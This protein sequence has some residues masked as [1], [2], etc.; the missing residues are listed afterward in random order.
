MI[1]PCFGLLLLA[2]TACG[3]TPQQTMTPIGP[4]PVRAPSVYG[5]LGERER[6]DLTSD[7]IE[8]LD[9]IGRWLASETEEIRDDLAPRPRAGRQ[10]PD[11]AEIA[12][13]GEA[14]TAA[15]VQAIEG[16]ESLL[17]AEQRETVCALQRE[18]RDRADEAGATDARPM[19]VGGGRNM[20]MVS[21]A[22]WTWCADEQT[23]PPADG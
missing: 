15:N 19:T 18:A 2:L 1:R 3:G 20:G 22:R 4:P 12:T 8:A 16:V 5:L 7:Q 11:S 23:T 17:S 10:Q 13:L 14:I 6:L 21:R 9:S